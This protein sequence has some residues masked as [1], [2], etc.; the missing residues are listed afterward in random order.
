MFSTKPS[1]P[2]AF[3]S[4]FEG[5]GSPNL[6]GYFLILVNGCEGSDD[7]GYRYYAVDVAALEV[8]V[9]RLSFELV[10]LIEIWSP[11]LVVQFSQC[12]C[13]VSQ[14]G[15]RSLEMSKSSFQVV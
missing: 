6:S 8:R 4:K 7:S 5:I 15:C 1:H 13:L 14:F 11:P 9:P 10:D 3:L 2:P 12:P